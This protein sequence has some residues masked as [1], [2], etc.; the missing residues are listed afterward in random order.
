MPRVRFPGWHCLAFVKWNKRSSSQHLCQPEP[1]Q[2]DNTKHLRVV[3]KRI[4]R[5]IGPEGLSPRGV[6]AWAIESKGKHSQEGAGPSSKSF[7]LWETNESLHLK[8]SWSGGSR[9]AVGMS[10]LTPSPAGQ[11]PFKQQSESKCQRLP[12]WKD[13]ALTHGYN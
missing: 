13:K 8:L 4:I 1:L 3:S 5:G 11:E 10:A 2:T 6:K 7:L 9:Y 12:P